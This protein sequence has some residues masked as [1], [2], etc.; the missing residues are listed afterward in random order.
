MRAR[1][2]NIA[3]RAFDPGCPTSCS[4]GHSVTIDSA[5]SAFTPQ[6]RIMH[7]FGHVASHL[8][9]EFQACADYSRDGDSGWNLMTAEYACAS[10]EEGLATFFGDTAIYWY[11]NPQPFTCLSSS[12]CTG[13][14][15]EA[16][17][18]AGSCTASERRWALTVDRYL[19]DLY[20][21]TNEAS[22]SNSASYATF[23]DTLER[24]PSGQGEGEDT[25]PFFLVFLDDPDGRSARDFRRHFE[26]LTGTSTQTN[27]TANCSPVGD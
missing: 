15:V 26:A 8:S 5:G 16:S 19:R 2:T 18:G 13:F 11:Q 21:S 1:F 14:D 24:F 7:E 20:D 9:N 17:T 22:D 10:F 23:F 25:E 6:G 4:D 12:Y 3:V 27:F